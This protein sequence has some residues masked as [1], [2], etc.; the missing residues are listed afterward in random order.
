[1][2]YVGQAPLFPGAKFEATVQVPVK[3]TTVTGAVNS[4]SISVEGPKVLGVKL[5]GVSVDN[6]LG[7]LFG[8]SPKPTA[9]A[10]ANQ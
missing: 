10:T 3:G 8:G 4:Q 7:G 1:M 9:T 2:D 5:P 6:P